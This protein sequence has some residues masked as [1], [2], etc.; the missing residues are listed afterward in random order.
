[1]TDPYDEPPLVIPA[2]GEPVPVDDT[3]APDPLYANRLL[4]ELARTSAAWRRDVAPFDAEIARLE[5]RRSD[6]ALPHVTR[7]ARIEHALTGWHEAVLAADPNRKTIHLPA[8][9]L[10]S[11]AAQRDLSINADEFL[12][13][14]R[15]HMTDAVRRPDPP[16]ET[17]DR[18]VV[19]KALEDVA[20]FHDDGRVTIAGEIVPGVTWQPGGDLAT[21]RNHYRDLPDIDKGEA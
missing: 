10:R 11:V 4:R 13:W 12:A 1:M 17:P 14:A 7:A 16:P 15:L 2:D 21:G 20:V 9:T 3:G 19:K 6:V 5:E 18:K 8:G